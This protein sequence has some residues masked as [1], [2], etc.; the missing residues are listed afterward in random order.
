MI[1]ALITILLCR[2]EVC[3]DLS[4]ETQAPAHHCESSLWQAEAQRV[5]PIS[6]YLDAGYQVVKEECTQ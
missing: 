6:L 1:P 5:M 3:I 2:G 4:Y